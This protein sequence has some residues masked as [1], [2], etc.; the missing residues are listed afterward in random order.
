MT[1]DAAFPVEMHEAG[2]GPNSPISVTVHDP[3][4]QWRNL[5]FPSLSYSKHSHLALEERTSKQSG[6][7][8]L[9]DIH[10]FI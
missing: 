10:A 8:L 1:I 2:R 7:F 6:L 3:R 4:S 5:L 9:P